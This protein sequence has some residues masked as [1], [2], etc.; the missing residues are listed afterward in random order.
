MASVLIESASSSNDFGDVRASS[1]DLPTPYRILSL[2]RCFIPVS[3]LDRS[4]K[5]FELFKA[6]PAKIIRHVDYG[7]LHRT[8][9]SVESAFADHNFS[10]NNGRFQAAVQEPFD[11]FIV[12]ARNAGIF[13]CFTVY[14]AARTFFIYLV[15]GLFKNVLYTFSAIHWQCSLG[16]A[17]I[18]SSLALSFSILKP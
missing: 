16:S 17:F 11:V 9:K 7:I 1:L 14:G 15:K 10:V 5:L 3:F 2:V 4:F 8:T 13:R 6:C 12:E 18:N